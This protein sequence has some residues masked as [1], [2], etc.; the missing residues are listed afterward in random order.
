[1]SVNALLNQAI[2][3]Y[4]KTSYDSYGR[5]VNSG[6]ETVQARFQP[7]TKTRLM[8]NNSVIVIDAIAYVP[9]DTTVA[10]D[11]RVSYGGQNYKVIGTYP[12][13]D[14]QG[15]TSH[16]KLELVKWQT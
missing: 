4:S 8:P 1:M 13:P 7:Q 15:K 2:R 3:L 12:T 16:I 9:S 10:I 6:Y 11:D 5:V 14:G